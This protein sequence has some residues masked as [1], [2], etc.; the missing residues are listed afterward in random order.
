MEFALK[1]SALVALGAFTI[2][3]F[4]LMIAI[5]KIVRSIRETTEVLR[6]MGKNVS[7]LKIKLIDS[8]NEINEVKDILNKTLNGVNELK[9][10]AVESFELIDGTTKEFG[11]AVWD[12]RKKADGILN[13]FSPFEKLFNHAFK[14]IAPSVLTTT[15]TISAFSKAIS[16]FANMLSKKKDN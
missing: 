3:A 2:L 14:K 7:E 10:K 4:I 1:V 11:D 6:E 5:T 15:G 16:V 12:I 13:M 8:L 9:N